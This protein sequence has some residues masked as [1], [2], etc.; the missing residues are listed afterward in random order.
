MTLVQVPN[1][2]AALLFGSALLG[3]VGVKR[4][5]R[6]HSDEPGSSPIYGLYFMSI[7]PAENNLHPTQNSEPWHTALN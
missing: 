3:V 5:R 2:A 1:P 7:E 4:I 6:R